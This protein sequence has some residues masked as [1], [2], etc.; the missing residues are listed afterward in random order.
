MLDGDALWADERARRVGV[1]VV[2]PREMLAA[3]I[4]YSAEVWPSKLQRA[5]VRRIAV[6]LGVE[7]YAAARPV[8]PHCIAQMREHG[9]SLAYFHEAHLESDEMHAWFSRREPMRPL[10]DDMLVELARRY[11]C[12]CDTEGARAAFFLADMLNATAASAG[13]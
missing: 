10:T 7:S 13:R 5:G 8:L 12:R 3:E 9:I 1:C 4:A 2:A 6:V 11:R